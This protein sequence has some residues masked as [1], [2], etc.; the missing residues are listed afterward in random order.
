VLSVSLW[1]FLKIEA[2]VS[3]TM[4]KHPVPLSG[5]GHTPYFIISGQV[6][7]YFEQDFCREIHHEKKVKK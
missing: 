6:G 1:D 4:F 3:Y 5:N 2:F 7:K